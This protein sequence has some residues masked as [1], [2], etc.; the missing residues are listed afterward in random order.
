MGVPISTTLDMTKVR[1][2]S[3]P[4]IEFFG[5]WFERPPGAPPP[6]GIPDFARD[7]IRAGMLAY[8]VLR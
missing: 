6:A 8:G 3:K 1:M 2:I 5:P 7:D 4:T